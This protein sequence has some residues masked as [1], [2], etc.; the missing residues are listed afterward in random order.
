VALITFGV[1]LV[2]FII[3][4]RIPERVTS[5]V[6]AAGEPLWRMQTEVRGILKL[7]GTRGALVAASEALRVENETLRLERADHILLREENKRLRELLG[8]VSDTNRIPAEVLLH[9]NAAPY[10]TFVIDVG[11]HDGVSVGDL[12]FASERILIG[13]VEEVQQDTA[14]ARLFS[15]P[16]YEMVVVLAESGV[17]LSAI[18]SGGGILL[19]EVPRD[20]LVEQGERVM[21]PGITSTLIGLVASVDV[22]AADAFQTVRVRLPIN[23]YTLRN[24]FIEV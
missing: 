13:V 24:V 4:A 16:G 17:E 19:L 21:S 12:V 20:V 7:F 11:G 14:R 1:F 3:G 6:Y 2:L 9:P 22:R 5:L 10:D 23:I 18:G 8:R 15:S